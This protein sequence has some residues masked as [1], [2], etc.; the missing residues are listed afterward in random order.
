MGR[1]RCL[2][3]TVRWLRFHGRCAHGA[4]AGRLE[5]ACLGDVTGC[6][7]RFLA[8][9]S[10][11][12]S[13]LCSRVPFS[14]LIPSPRLRGEGAR[15]ADEGASGASRS[16]ATHPYSPTSRLSDTSGTRPCCQRRTKAAIPRMAI[17]Q[18]F[19][20]SHTANHRVS[21]AANEL[22][23]TALERT[24]LACAANKITRESVSFGEIRPKPNGICGFI[25]GIARCLASSS[26]GSIASGGTSSTSYVSSDRWW[27]SW[28]A[29]STSKRPLQ[30][31]AERW[32]W[33][34][35]GI[36]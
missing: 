33:K 17:T 31:R 24:E 35:W 18:V 6:C 15:R 8:S 36:G 9:C 32:V 21:P 29:A 3:K 34:G 10:R 13:R 7:F 19:P 1:N 2:G 14:R 28:M 20:I 5:V 22:T 11:L 4:C 27:W 25:C 26:G 30:T 23:I 16:F 12:L